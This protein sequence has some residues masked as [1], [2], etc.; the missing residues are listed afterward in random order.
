VTFASVLH[1]TWLGSST[2]VQSGPIPPLRI[3]LNS[4][5]RIGYQQQRPALA[6]KPQ[7]VL[8]ACGIP[9]QYTV[10]T[11]QP[12]VAGLRDRSLGQRR[13]L[14]GGRGFLQQKL[15]DLL[16]I[17]SGKTEIEIWAPLRKV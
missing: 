7:Y 3:Q 13:R 9:A 16:G 8:P 6:Q 12:Q 5:G 17:E 4:V 2:P 15:V 1:V 10:R 11:T 14:I